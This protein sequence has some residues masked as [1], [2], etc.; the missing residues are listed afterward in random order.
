MDRF[1]NIIGRIVRAGA[2]AGS[3][4]L[5]IVTFIIVL[6][7]CMRFFGEMISGHYELVSLLVVIS[8]A[9]TLSYT[10][11]H[12]GHISMQL[13]VSRLSPRSQTIIGL[14]TTLVSIAVWGTIAWASITVLR[15]KWLK[16][17]SNMLL[18]PYLP[19]RC[20]WVFGLVL[21]CLV[22]V[23]DLFRPF[24]RKKQVNGPD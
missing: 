4:F 11:I 23:T 20:I 21:F 6:N 13:V 14:F 19:F 12:H 9:F 3:A 18:I 1:V 24:L 2:I 8:V 15:D 17:L 22:L 7:I 5:L 16:E 10:A